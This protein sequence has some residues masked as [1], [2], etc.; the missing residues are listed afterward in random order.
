V[1]GA[2]GFLG[3]EIATELQLAGYEV[4]AIVRPGSDSSHLLE[5][6]IV[7]VEGDVTNPIDMARAMQGQAFV[8]HAAALV[9][10]SGADATEFEWVN[11][12]GTRTVCEA[13]VE[14]G[15]TRLLHVSTAHV[16][17]IQ[18]GAIINESSTPVLHPHEGYD[19]SK[20]AA[21]AVV[22]EYS[23]ARLDSVVINPAVVF[24]PRSRYSGRLIN[25]F[26]NGRL[27]V[28]PLPDRTL[29]LVYSGDVGRGAR[30][31]L[32]LGKP[33]EHYILAG[34]TVTVR[35]FIGVLANVSGRRTPR[36]YL[37]SWAVT[38][39]VAAA[40]TVSPITRWRPPVTLAGIRH[41]GTVYDGRRAERELGLK[42]T[43]LEDA[44]ATT[45]EW[46]RTRRK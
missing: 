44:L 19:A 11:V 34:P 46:L 6:G 24:G 45:V 29:S 9:P 21:E 33:G 39:G 37:P 15:V 26:L 41:G 27:P 20:V 16:F 28:I 14:A 36:L 43:P 5:Q 40:R 10:G 1:T 32:E 4:T 35:E 22:A 38:L 12:G 13:A 23:S 2:T 18:P 17:G 3:G 30:L 31:A 7:L 42:Y 8:C 25:L